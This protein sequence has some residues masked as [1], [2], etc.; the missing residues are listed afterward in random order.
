[1]AHNEGHSAQLVV[2]TESVKISQQWG[3]VN[4]SLNIYQK[5]NE[6]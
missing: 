3:F 5:R 6:L 4:L 2:L 1:M